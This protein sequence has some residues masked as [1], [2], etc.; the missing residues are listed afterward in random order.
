MFRHAAFVLAVALASVPALAQDAPVEA[1]KPADDAKSA[2]SGVRV[3]LVNGRTIDG[4]L[5]VEGGW[6]R[7]D[8]QK[9]WTKCDK[10]DAGASLRVW[11][12]S[13]AS[14]YCITLRAE[15]VKSFEAAPSS[16]GKPDT[17]VGDAETEAR[18]SEE[19]AR[20]RKARDARFAAAAAAAKKKADDDAAR[21]KAAED[22]ERARIEAAL[23]AK[24]P[25]PAWSAERV[26]EI[27]RRQLI[28]DLLPTADEREFIAVYPVWARAVAAAE[29][30]AEAEKRAAEEKKAEA[31]RKAAEEAAAEPAPA[32]ENPQPAE[33]APEP[34]KEEGKPAAEEEK[35]APAEAPAPAPEKD[36]APA[37][38]DPVP[39]APEKDEKQDAGDAK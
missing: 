13:G 35:P 23:I 6:E 15:E 21:K 16:S 26:K 18:R 14:A 27:E 31:E 3:T 29:A 19:A 37:P 30:K 7:L 34:V 12:G 10:A 32:A 20:S 39:P 4:D 9:G 36:E 1:A 22:A 38:S 17:G 25:P 2:G 28:M 5:R 8:P 11:R 24:F 33:A